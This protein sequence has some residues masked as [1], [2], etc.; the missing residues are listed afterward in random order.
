MV[1]Q[2]FTHTQKMHTHTRTQT[3]THHINSVQRPAI[4][5]V[6]D[7]ADFDDNP[8]RMSPRPGNIFIS[9]RVTSGAPGSGVQPVERFLSQRRRRRRRCHRLCRRV[10]PHCTGVPFFRSTPPHNRTLNNMYQTCETLSASKKTAGVEI[11][12]QFTI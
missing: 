6:D 10:T 12:S 5:A 9:T 11:F 1:L 2:H 3:L 7:G 4:C 8:L